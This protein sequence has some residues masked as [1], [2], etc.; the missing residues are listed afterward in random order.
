MIYFVSYL[1]GLARENSENA[2]SDHLDTPN[3]LKC[4]AFIS[5][6]LPFTT[7]SSPRKNNT[8]Q[9]GLRL[10]PDDFKGRELVLNGL[11]TKYTLDLKVLPVKLHCNYHSLCLTS[12]ML[13]DICFFDQLKLI[14]YSDIL[15]FQSY[16]V[17]RASCSICCLLNSA[18]YTTG[19]VF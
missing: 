17:F 7:K 1:L 8:L 9:S 4:S 6:Q 2:I 16:S 5:A 10:T 3:F 11:K 12:P 19:Q 18:I 15:F 14:L 13:I